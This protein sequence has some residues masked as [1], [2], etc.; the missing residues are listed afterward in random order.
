MRP[1][2]IPTRMVRVRVP[3]IAVLLEQARARKLSLPDY[4]DYI[5]KKRTKR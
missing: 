5:L 3:T 1:K 2:R 4:I